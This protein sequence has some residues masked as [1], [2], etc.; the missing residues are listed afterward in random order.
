MS[1][2]K[3]SSSQTGTQPSNHRSRPSSEIKW[4]LLTALSPIVWGTTY[5][6]TTALLPAGHPLFSGLM[7]SLSAGIIG[8]I[9]TRRL[10]HGSWWW[11]SLIL[12]VLNMAMFFPL[13]F[14]TAQHLPGGVAAT[15]TAA[16]PILI[17]LLAPPLLH[18]SFSKRGFV[19]GLAGLAG[20]ACVVLGPG[21]KLD[22][23]GIISGILANAG[24]AAGITLTKRW[25]QPENTSAMAMTSWQLTWA[26]IVLLIPAFCIDGV[27][28]GIGTKAV[29]GYL[30]LGLIGGLATYTIW[31]AGIR[32]LP[33]TSTGMLG[34]LS[35][36]TAAALGVLLAGE[37][38]TPIQIL[39]FII[40]LAA[41]LF[42]QS[43]TQSKKDIG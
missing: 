7:R 4:T 17:T 28:S 38:L 36:L 13:L 33:V 32:R 26:G 43:T 10:P 20:V 41:M 1:I 34:L 27:P 23:I 37:T 40:A 29:C 22:V 18:Q 9:I 3:P 39:G 30:W 25:G 2:S 19:W 6:S 16:Q 12:G 31:T 42:G 24:M 21:A 15:F 14:V 5:L 35:P 8:L 11:K